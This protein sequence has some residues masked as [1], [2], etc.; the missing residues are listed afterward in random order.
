[1]SGGIG[2]TR[3]SGGASGKRSGSS[4]RRRGA[5][6]GTGIAA[7]HSALGVTTPGPRAFTP[8]CAHLYLHSRARCTHGL[9]GQLCPRRP[10]CAIGYSVWS[11]S[12]VQA[13]CARGTL[14][15]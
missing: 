5:R 6:S 15:C 14:G 10:L 13:E 2:R 12:G 4:D 1:M 9:P 7:D 11:G 3:E 8:M